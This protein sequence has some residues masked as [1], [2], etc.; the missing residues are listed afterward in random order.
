[1]VCA[2]SKILKAPPHLCSTSPGHGSF[3]PQGDGT[4]S[5]PSKP[6]KPLKAGRMPRQN[7]AVC[8]FVVNGKKMHM[9]HEK[10][11][12]KHQKY[13]RIKSESWKEDT[14]EL[15][16]NLYADHPD[17]FARLRRN[18]ITSHEIKISLQEMFEK[19]CCVI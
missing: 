11:L 7:D 8:L 4:K 1:M 5:T 2:T 14:S 13:I 18:V 3:F 6:H 15:N 17:T 19:V 10:S 9:I 12:K 16:Q